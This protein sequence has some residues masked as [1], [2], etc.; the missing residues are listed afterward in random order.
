MTYDVIC[1]KTVII[2]ER[3]SIFCEA[4]LANFK[5]IFV[6]GLHLQFRMESFLS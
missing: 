2:Y 6:H 1:W 5:S 3:G 4:D